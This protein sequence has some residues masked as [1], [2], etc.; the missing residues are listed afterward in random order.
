MNDS[1][2][3]PTP[4]ALHRLVQLRHNDVVLGGRGG[5]SQHIQRALRGAQGMWVVVREQVSRSTQTGALR[6]ARCIS[7]PVV[8]AT[9][10]RLYHVVLCFGYSVQTLIAKLPDEPI[11]LLS[12]EVFVTIR[13][14]T[15][16]S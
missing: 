3:R 9:A 6:C 15:V 2:T 14:H 5:G 8:S 1:L 11:V 10:L 12:G 7:Y 13:Q 4:I 16:A